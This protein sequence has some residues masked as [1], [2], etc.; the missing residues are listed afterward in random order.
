[1]IVVAD[2]SPLI[3]LNK[4]RQLELLHRLLGDDIRIPTVVRDEVLPPDL[5]PIEAE[6]LASFVAACTIDPVRRPRQFARAMSAADSAALTLALRVGADVLLC[7]ERLTRIVAETE[8]IR[9]LGTLGVLLKAH[10]ADLLSREETHELV[11]QLVG[12]HGFRISV[13]LYQA[14]LEQ[15][16]R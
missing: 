5:D 16:R 15:L 14:V 11:D 6:S 13:D 2:A 8:G 12:R 7:D 4:L 1:M 9:P 3:F 10:R